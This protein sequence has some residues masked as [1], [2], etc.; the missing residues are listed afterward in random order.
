MRPA[1]GLLGVV[2]VALSLRAAGQPEPAIR[3][4]SPT[5]GTYLSG[6]IVLQVE[7]QGI[8]LSA[9]EDVTFFADGR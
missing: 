9:L 5:S 3:F 2:I 1:I 7:V 4:I 6:P 8:E